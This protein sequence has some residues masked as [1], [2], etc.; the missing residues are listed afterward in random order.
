MY[1]LLPLMNELPR[2]MLIPSAALT[3]QTRV[4]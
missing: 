3:Y 1:R 2:S 4:G